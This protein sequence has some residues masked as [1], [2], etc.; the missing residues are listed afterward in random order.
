MLHHGPC[1]LW[2]ATAH[3]PQPHRHGVRFHRRCRRQ[4]P[5]RHLEP[6]VEHP[7]NVAEA[8][9]GMRMVVAFIALAGA[10]AL[11]STREWWKRITLMMLSIPVALL[12]NVTRGD[13]GHGHAGRQRRPRARRTLIGTLLLIPGLG[14]FTAVGW[15]ARENRP[16]HQGTQTQG[17]GPKAPARSCQTRHGRAARD[18]LRLGD[19]HGLGD[20]L[21]QDPPQQAPHLRPGNRVV[22]SIPRDRFVGAGRR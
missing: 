3:H 10:V 2:P 21:L 22:S 20:Q 13:H 19:R 15:A 16:H 8:C 6:G 17:R 12:M 9:S 1:R 5:D 7:L 4:R 18:P 11:L 14:L